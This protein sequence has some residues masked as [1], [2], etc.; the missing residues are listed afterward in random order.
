MSETKLL[1]CPFCGADVMHV[2]G[3]SELYFFKCINCSAVVSFDDDYINNNKDRAE[4]AYNTRSLMIA[5]DLSNDPL[6][7][8]ELRQ[9]C[10]EPVWVSVV[11]HSC[12]C[13]PN[14][15][16]DGWGLCRKS[17]VR[18]WDAKRADLLH[19]D[20]DFEEYGTKWLAYRKKPQEVVADETAGGN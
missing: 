14:D 12:L 5:L 1:P 8:D 7:V 18:L 20:W 17:W 2:Q 16:F 4:Q 19:V 9:M 10:G 13:D 3:L 6:T 15:D 11:D